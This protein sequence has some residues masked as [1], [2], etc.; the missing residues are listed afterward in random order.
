MLV[1]DI[2]LTVL[3]LRQESKL[4]SHFCALCTVFVAALKEEVSKITSG[5][6]K[7]PRK[8]LTSQIKIILNYQHEFM[9]SDIFFTSLLNLFLK[10]STFF[11]DLVTLEQRASCLL[12]LIQQVSHSMMGRNKCSIFDDESP[13]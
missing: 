13:T 4:T 6:P 11:L 12:L 10:L 7:I 9:S 3:I 1:Y 5:K 2:R 8:I